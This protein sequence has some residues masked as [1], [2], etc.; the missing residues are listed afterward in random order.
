VTPARAMWLR[1][2]L[3]GVVSGVMAS[4]VVL[5][6][7]AAIEFG[8]FLL[9][10]RGEHGPYAG[11]DPWLRLILPVAGG[12]LLGLVFDRLHT[13][14]RE[15]GVVHVLRRLHTPG[16]ECLPTANLF[17]QI[18]GAVTAIVAGHAVDTEGPSVHIGAASASRLGQRL[19]TS[20]E[21]DHT[22]AACGAAAAIAAAFNTPLAGI[23]FVVEVLKVRYE[24]SRFLPI[25]VASVVGAVMNRLLLHADPTLSVPPLDLNNYWEL[26]NLILL[27][28][29]IGLLAI[30]FI[31]LCESVAAHTRTWSS[32]LSFTL[33]GLVT[34][35]LALGTPQIMG[36]SYATLD[37]L[38]TSKEDLGVGLVL[39]IT[40]TK[41]VATGTAVGLRVP[42]G[43]IGPTLFIGGAAGSAF[44]VLFGMVAPIATAPPAFYA[45]I[46]MVAM[47]GAS[48]RAPLAALIALLE[49]T[50]NPNVILPGMLAVA[51]ADITN[52]LAIGRESVFE[53]LSRSRGQS[54]QV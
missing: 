34:G 41:L 3:L 32:S 28:L 39:A 6:F 5:A 50:G 37:Q 36:T 4:L 31:S 13:R 9:L 21:E 16:K 44:G 45:I 23:V 10:P 53:I 52:Q 22:L 19:R 27:G 20:A 46:G 42:G 11:L 1:L 24:V 43:L 8:Q 47:M 17:T 51:T 49:L 54:G 30:G 12:L 29:T 40:L 26:P 25:I 2:T 18:G 15:V 38:L 48:L 14:H 33:S 35:I 7:R